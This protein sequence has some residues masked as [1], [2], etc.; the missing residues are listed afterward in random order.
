MFRIGSRVYPRE[1]ERLYVHQ[2]GDGFVIVSDFPEKDLE[3]PISI[4]TVLMQIILMN[5]GT[6]RA[7]ISHGGFADILGCYPDEIGDNLNDAGYL[8]LGAGIMTVFQVMGDALIN[9]HKL[10][11]K[12]PKGPCLFVDLGLISYIP[13][14][15]PV[16]PKEDRGIL[17]I[18]WLHLNNSTVKRIYSGIGESMVSHNVFETLL[19]EYIKS[20]QLNDEWVQNATDI[21]S[22]KKI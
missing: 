16:L 8:R 21:I 13:Q 1:V 17:S 4:A 10:L 5:G 19:N 9:S 7:G 11:Q 22:N 15:V 20:N 12:S 14:T 6:A 3:R 18:D 2:L